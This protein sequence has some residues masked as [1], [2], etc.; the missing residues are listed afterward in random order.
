MAMTATEFEA[1]QH[2]Y[3]YAIKKTD[4]EINE[5][6]NSLPEEVKYRVS[7]NSGT[8]TS[9]MTVTEPSAMQQ[10]TDFVAETKTK[11]DDLRAKKRELMAKC[12]QMEDDLETFLLS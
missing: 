9:E 6:I 2:L 1:K 10:Y 3:A 4:A 11:L 7:N 8:E 12:S 5:I